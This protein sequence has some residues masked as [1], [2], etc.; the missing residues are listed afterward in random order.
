M[1]SH[2]KTL[3]NK[4]TWG[5]HLSSVSGEWGATFTLHH[6]DSLFQN[7]ILI[8]IL[9]IQNT[10]KDDILCHCTWP[11]KINY[12]H[13]NWHLTL[14]H[15]ILRICVKI[16]NV[17]ILY[18]SLKQVPSHTN[19]ITRKY[20]STHVYTLP[21]NYYSNSFHFRHPNTPL[22]L[23]HISHKQL[24]TS[25]FQSSSQSTRTHCITTHCNTWPSPW[26]G[27]DP[28]NQNQIK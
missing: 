15:V 1:L 13:S 20:I 7:F 11:M 26:L 16:Q 27:I 23:H 10:N 2:G 3:S 12:L 6:W 4:K 19:N 14:W 9:Y 8:S 18:L 17:D 24:Q 28:I 5:L 25:S 21:L 22:Q